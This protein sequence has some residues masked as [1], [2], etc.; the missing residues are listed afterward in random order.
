MITE[1]EESV[2]SLTEQ[3]RNGEI[4][5]D[6]Y[7]SQLKELH[8]QQIQLKNSY[9]EEVDALKKE[10]GIMEELEKKLKKS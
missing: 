1:N 6:E 4:T 8:H 5:K 10:D 9:D 7:M 3:Y 2:K